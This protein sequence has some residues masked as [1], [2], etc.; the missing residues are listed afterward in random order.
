[1][2]EVLPIQTKDEQERICGLCGARY[3]PAL[4]AYA[5]YGD[6]R[7]CGVCQF[8]LSPEG[9]VIETLD[10]IPGNDDF[11][12]VF[13]MG[14]AALSFM[15]R[16]GAEFGYYDGPVTEENRVLIGAVGFR[17]DPGTGRFSVDLRGFFDHPCSHG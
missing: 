11:Q 12:P 8:R 4:L 17:P 6:G 16:C 7:L 3:D 13:V 15:E 10:Q 14:R 9:G 2:L 5:A 1:M